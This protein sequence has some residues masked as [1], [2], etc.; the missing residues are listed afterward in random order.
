MAK[1]Y[2]EQLQEVSS[3]QNTSLQG[4]MTKLFILPIA[5]FFLEVSNTIGAVFGL[6][7]TPVQTLA[8]GV[9]NL[10]ASLFGI[11][12]SPGL[13]GLVDSAVAITSQDIQIFGIVALPVAALLLVATAAIL[14][15]G[16]SLEITGNTA[17][18]VPTDIPFIGTDEEEEG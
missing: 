5:A 16:R 1:D 3:I 14:A 17:L 2:I 15:F 13:A 8:D 10:I 12:T 4:V 11:N 9:G 18:F 7:I 6:V